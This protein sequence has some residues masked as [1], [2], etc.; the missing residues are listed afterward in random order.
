MIEESSSIMKEKYVFQ[1]GSRP[2]SWSESAHGGDK[3][4]HKWYLE[5]YTSIENYSRRDLTYES[6]KL[7]ALSGYAHAMQEVLEGTYLAGLWKQD[8]LIGML[9]SAFSTRNRLR[10]PNQRRCPTWS[11]AALD[12]AIEY[13]LSWIQYRNVRQESR[14]QLKLV[15]G[16][17]QLV[18]S[19]MMGQVRLGSLTVSGHIKK[20][21]CLSA[22]SG[23]AWVRHDV[24][25]LSD[26]ENWDALGD[27][28]ADEAQSSPQIDSTGKAYAI[29]LFDTE[30]ARPKDIW[31]LAVVS[32]RGI[33]LEYLADKDVY[34]RVGFFMFSDSTWMSTS[35]VSTITI[36]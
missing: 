36:V 17:V 30:D 12:G 21:K 26:V 35:P 19:D 25:A 34:Q 11:W 27:F 23:V 8:L 3:I 29:C 20:V 18:G 33:V 1:E 10:H 24:S 2:L 14:M 28:V 22:R 13:H 9:W 16:D 15:K 5:W 4:V 7:P 6:D 32:T 31:C